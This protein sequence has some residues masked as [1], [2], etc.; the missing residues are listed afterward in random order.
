M[1][2][3]V[4]EPGFDPGGGGG[5]GSGWEDWSVDGIWVGYNMFMFM[6]MFMLLGYLHILRHRCRMIVG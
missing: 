3:E 1:P 5:G 6:S 4:G 2:V